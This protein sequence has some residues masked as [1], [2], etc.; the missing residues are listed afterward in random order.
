MSH[1]QT[2][3]EIESILQQDFEPTSL[4]VIDDSHKHAGHKEAKKNPGAGHFHVV[5]VSK[6]FE[7]QSTVQRHRMIYDA[8]ADLMPDKI[9]ALS[10]KI[11]L[12]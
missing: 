3:S 8:L 5:I 1:Q 11:T 2:K 6:K 7:G 9:H 4:E 12:P 10:L